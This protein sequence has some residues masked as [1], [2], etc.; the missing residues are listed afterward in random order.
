MDPCWQSWPTSL[1]RGSADPG[2]Y[3]WQ[4]VRFYDESQS[5]Q[6]K[7]VDGALFLWRYEDVV[8][9]CVFYFHN[10]SLG[11]EGCDDELWR[12]R[13]CSVRS[14]LLLSRLHSG[15]GLPWKIYDEPRIFIID[16]VC[17]MTKF[18]NIT[19]KTLLKLL[20]LLVDVHTSLYGSR[21]AIFYRNVWKVIEKYQK[22]ALGRHQEGIVLLPSY[23]RLHTHI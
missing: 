8:L 17:L 9:W 15:W 13:H 12:N 1:G 18:Q 3:T 14:V 11:A 6:V 22:G 2:R 10:N 23:Q 20:F 16:V 7:G 4:S 21:L 5:S 19:H